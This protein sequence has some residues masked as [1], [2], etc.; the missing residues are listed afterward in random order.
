M[1]IRDCVAAVVGAGPLSRA[2]ADKLESPGVR[3]V[4]SAPGEGP[5]ATVRRAADAGPLGILVNCFLDGRTGK[6]E[7]LQESDWSE[8]L[9]A[10]VAAT[11]LACRAA[12]GPMRE[13]QY[14]R[15][16]N[17]SDRQYLGAPG[18]AAFA[19]AQAGV[20]SLTRTLALEAARDGITVNCVVAGTIDVGQM[21]ALPDEQR[22]RLRKLQPVG[23]L[24]KP[25][26]VANAVLFFASDESVYI[27]GQ[28]LFVCGG[29]SVY[30]SLSV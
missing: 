14:G 26:D 4:T 11:G 19:A 9:T 13:Q 16:I 20:V 12:L 5:E 30:S 25:E 8:S 7:D 3:V 15:I 10:A 27:T 22:E 18:N 1:S 28:V 6:V 2:I 17:V 29:T 21:E 24:G 23:R